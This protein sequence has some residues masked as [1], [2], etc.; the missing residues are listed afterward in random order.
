MDNYPSACKRGSSPYHK[1]VTAGGVPFNQAQIMS[2]TETDAESAPGNNLYTE[3]DTNG[4]CITVP[5]RICDINYT[6]SAPAGYSNYQWYQS[7]DNGANF[8]PY[9]TTQSITITQEG[10]YTFTV[11][12]AVLGSCG[13]QLCCPFVVIK[14]CCTPTKCITIGI[15]K[16]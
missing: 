11:D 9:A 14:D 4:S 2:I 12:N 13:N 3:D 16:Y 7:T 10:Q 1:R 6:L 5:I 8:V 15:T